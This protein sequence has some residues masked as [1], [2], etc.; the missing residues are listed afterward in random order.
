[1]AATNNTQHN[2]TLTVPRSITSTAKIMHAASQPTR[3]TFRHRVLLRTG[4]GGGNPRLIRTYNSERPLGKPA[5]N[6]GTRI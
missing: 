6:C 5:L 1:M 4:G 3:S 2:L